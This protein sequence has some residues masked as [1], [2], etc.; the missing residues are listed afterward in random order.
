MPCDRDTCSF[1]NVLVHVIDHA[2]V[3]DESNKELNFFVLF[4]QCNTSCLHVLYL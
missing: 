2:A 1:Y 3:N 4:H